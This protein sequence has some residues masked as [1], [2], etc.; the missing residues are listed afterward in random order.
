MPEPSSAIHSAVLDLPHPFASRYGAP[1]I[2]G[3]EAGVFL[4]RYFTHCLQC[5]FCHDWC[6]QFGVDVDLVHHARLMEHAAGL[7]AVTGVPRDQWFDPD[8]D[9][10]PEMP[11]GG[12]HR[13]RV[14][15]GAC[16]FL[17][18]RGRGCHIHAYAA[19]RGIDYHDLK[20]IIDCLFPLTFG[21][22]VLYAAEEVDDGDLVCLDQGPTIYRGL[23]DEV[24]YYFGDACIAALDNVERTV[25]AG[26]RPS[27]RRDP[28]SVIRRSTA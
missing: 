2:H 5:T 28:G 6:C 20:S 9:P 11:G 8:P 13:A 4:R 14:W 26:V 21:D 3:V 24:R 19:A 16:V 17:D 23:R 27:S 12:S 25:L 18:R 1:V 10:D 15:N 22:G 7:E